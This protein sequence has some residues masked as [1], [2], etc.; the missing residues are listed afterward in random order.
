MFVAWD[1]VA[2]RAESVEG[3]QPSGILPFKVSWKCSHAYLSDI[4][5]TP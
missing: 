3:L 4:H 1:E 5:N 2:E